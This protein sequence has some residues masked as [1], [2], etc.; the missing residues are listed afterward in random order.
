MF[1]KKTFVG[2]VLFLSIFLASQA[3]AGQWHRTEIA[4]WGASG[5]AYCN[6]Y[7]NV[8][9]RVGV[10]YLHPDDALEALWSR[11]VTA[12]QYRGGLYNYTGN[13]YHQWRS[14]W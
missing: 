6:N 9:I 4:Y 7:E 12:C 11:A 14:Y 13:T 1:N 3:L 5:T 10:S 2:V 8:H